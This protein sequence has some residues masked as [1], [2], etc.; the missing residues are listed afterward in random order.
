MT[1]FVLSVVFYALC[2]APLIKYRCHLHTYRDFSEA[3]I[4]VDFGLFCG[5]ITEYQSIYVRKGRPAGGKVELN[6][7]FFSAQS[8]FY[9]KKI[10]TKLLAIVVGTS[11]DR[12][13]STILCTYE[14]RY[15]YECWD[16][17]MSL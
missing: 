4:G 3:G 12:I 14:P 17:T 8:V 5:L 6:Q 16:H 15:F 9:E 2:T 11:F 13:Y 7:T 1:L 10:L